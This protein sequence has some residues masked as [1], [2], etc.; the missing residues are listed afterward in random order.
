MDDFIRGNSRKF[1]ANQSLPYFHVINEKQPGLY[2]LCLHAIE[3][4]LLQL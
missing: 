2:H 4:S 1:A 3:H